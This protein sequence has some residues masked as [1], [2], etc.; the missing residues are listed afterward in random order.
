[1][2]YLA[3][4]RGRGGL[5]LAIAAGRVIYLYP[6]RFEGPGVPAETLAVMNLECEERQLGLSL[7]EVI[8]SEVSRLNA[9][10][11]ISRNNVQEILGEELLASS[12]LTK[13]SPEIRLLA[14]QKFIKG[15]LQKQG[16]LY[17][18]SLSLTDVKTGRSV[19]VRSEATSR[20]EIEAAVR[21]LTADL[22]QKSS[23]IASVP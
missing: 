22:I 20:A 8:R 13:E 21:S 11:L 18:L 23:R 1:M 16:E 2:R 4:G 10:V 14:M 15:R 17:L 3:F 9:F 19:E 7:S 6:I 12:G 5:Q